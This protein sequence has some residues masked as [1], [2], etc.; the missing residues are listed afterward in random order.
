[1][2]ELQG[3]EWT[4]SL[5]DTPR[6]TCSTCHELHT[7]SNPLA[8]RDQQAENCATCHEDQ[9]TNHKRF[10]S[11]GIVFDQL[12]CSDCHDVHQLISKESD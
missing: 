11:K 1:M 4:G 5:H 3:M 8:N 9:I 2:G 12:A 10:E 7:T 6:M